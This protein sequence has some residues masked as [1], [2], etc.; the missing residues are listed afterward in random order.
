[1]VFSE[2]A[3]RAFRQS[4]TVVWLDTPVAELEK[5]LI[6]TLLDRGVATPVKMSL[7]EIY[8]MREPLYR[9]YADYRVPCDGGTELVV[10][11]LRDLLL[12]EKLI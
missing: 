6:G 2:E 5:R 7:S 11:N 1:M 4:G 10:S 3:M 12:R 9:K 8:E